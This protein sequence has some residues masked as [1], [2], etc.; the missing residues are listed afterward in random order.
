MVH[1]FNE[2]ETASFAL[3]DT[4][5]AVRALWTLHSGGLYT[6]SWEGRVCGQSHF[7]FRYQRELADL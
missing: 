3:D 1:E 2:I 5:L 6:A 4:G 7:N